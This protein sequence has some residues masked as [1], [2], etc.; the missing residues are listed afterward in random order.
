[1]QKYKDLKYFT[2]FTNSIRQRIQVN[3]QLLVSSSK[4]KTKKPLK[5]LTKNLKRRGGRNNHGR[6]TCFT[7][8]GGHK[9]NYRFISNKCNNKF[10]PYSVV[11]TLEYDPFR[12][13]IISCCFLKETGSFAYIIAPQRIKVGTFLAS[14]YGVRRPNYGS[15]CIL[16]YTQIGDLIYNINLNNGPYKHTISTSAGCFSKIIRKHMKCFFAIIKLPSGSFRSIS[17]GSLGF[18]GKTSNPYKKFEVIGKAGRNRWLGKRPSV[19]GVAMNPID[20]PHG[21][22]EGKSSG[23]RPS[24]T[25]WGFP[26]KGQPTKITKVSKY[27]IPKNL[28]GSFLTRVNKKLNEVKLEKERF[29]EAR[30]FIKKENFN[31][32]EKK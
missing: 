10:L 6:L 3:F 19:R 23:G 21:G 32:K 4:T 22:G 14:N 24:S 17:L 7:Q 29:Y 25:P 26:T 8:G 30:K 9:H 20:H 1:M 13:S 27:E 15:A 16:K 2:P 5:F 18:L 12:T 28:V 31:N 11:N